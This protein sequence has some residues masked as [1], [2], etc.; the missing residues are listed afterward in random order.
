MFY[1][2]FSLVLLLALWSATVHCQSCRRAGGTNCATAN[3]HC[4]LV[5][6]KKTDAISSLTWPPEK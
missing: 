4:S 6:N 5:Y 2:T 1:N 3:G